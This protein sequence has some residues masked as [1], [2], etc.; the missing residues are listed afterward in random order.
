MEQDFAIVCS[1]LSRSDMSCPLIWV[2]I[3]TSKW[4]VP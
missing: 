1:V 4:R 2:Y 3:D